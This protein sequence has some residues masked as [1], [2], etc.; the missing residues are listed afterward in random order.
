MKYIAFILGFFIAMPVMAQ[1]EVRDTMN[2]RRNF[3]LIEYAPKSNHLS[4]D[5]APAAGY[6]EDNDILTIKLGREFDWK[7][8]WRYAL[9]AGFTTFENSYDNT[10]N[11]LGVGAEAI[12]LVSRNVNLFGGGDFGFVSGYDGNVDDDYVIFGEYIPFFALNAGVEVEIN[13]YLPTLRG[14]VKYVPASIVG[15]DDVVALT[16]GTRIKF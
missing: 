9:A 8:N 4:N 7:P 16:I 5:D 1:T 14:G 10:S 15:S 6:N 13:D 11:G 2:D 3:V 12:Y